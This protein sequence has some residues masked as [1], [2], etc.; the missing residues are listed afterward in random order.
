LALVGA[1]QSAGTVKVTDEPVAN[2]PPAGATNVKTR[3]LVV[4][5]VTTDVGNTVIVPVPLAAGTWTFSVADAV[6][7]VTNREQLLLKRGLYSV[8]V[9]VKDPPVD[10]AV[11]EAPVKVAVP[12]DTWTQ[13][14]EGAVNVEPAGRPEPVN[15]T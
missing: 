8:A 3:E 2:E 13:L 4:E 11:T 12:P 10:P 5:P 1:V 15:V 6:A 14:L 9:I 7:E